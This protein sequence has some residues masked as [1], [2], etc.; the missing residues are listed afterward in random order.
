MKNLKSK[1]SFLSKYNYDHFNIRIIYAKINEYELKI[2]DK[3][4][5]YMNKGLQ[6]CGLN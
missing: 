1:K 2:K 6:N 3:G 4:Q 5:R